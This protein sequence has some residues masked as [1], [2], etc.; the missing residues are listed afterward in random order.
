MPEVLVAPEVEVV[1]P[2]ELASLTPEQIKVEESKAIGANPFGLVEHGFLTIKTKSRGLQKLYPNPAQKK[3]LAKVKELF[4]AGKPVRMIVLKARQAGFSTAIEAVIYAFVS[5]MRGVNAMVV[6]DDLEGANYIFEM[7]KLFQECLDKHLKPRTKASNEKKLGFAGLN[8]QILID[9]ADNANVGRKFTIQ[10]AH[11]SEVS[12]YPKSLEDMLSGLGHAVPHAMGTMMFL[13]ST[14][15]GYNEFYDLWVK[16]ING[17]TDWIPFF[18]AWFENPENSLPLE[19]NQLYP[20]EN[21]RFVTPMEKDNFLVGEKELKLKYTLTDE[22]INWR[23]WDL[24]NNCSGDINK[25]NEDNPACWEDAFVA[26]GN[27]FFN[28]EALKLQLIKNPLAVGNILKEDGRYIFREDPAGLFR[29]YEFPKRG[30]QYVVAGDSAEGLEHGDKSAGIAINK[31]T[32]KTACVY[33][34][35][36]PPERFEEDLIKMGNFYN[37][38]VIA[39]ENKGYGYAVNQGLYKHYGKVYRRVNSKKGPKEPTMELGFNTNSITRPQMLAQLAEEIAEGS[40][41]LLDI[42]LIGQ[43]WTFINNAKRGQPEAEKGKSDDLVMARAIASQVR[44]EQPYKEKV[45]MPK[46]R[47]VFRGLS[48]Y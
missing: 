33:N 2:P 27:L 8:S 34:H 12:R 14:A 39:C 25:F 44:M 7:Q 35:N 36:I 32:N 31:R 48:G 47:R 23:R 19:G 37:E 16:A 41:E 30:E 45:F 17:K 29:F 24:V 21:V 11:L 4:F 26:T 10:F 18:S 15:N 3:F 40:A 20:I 6:A 42:D 13:E 9:T 38:A 46:R 5:R 43:C 22:Q 1:I 28:R